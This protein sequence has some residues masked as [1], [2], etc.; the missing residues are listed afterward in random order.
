MHA[1]RAQEPDDFGAVAMI[2][3]A[4]R[5]PRRRPP[6]ANKRLA[7][8]IVT[9]QKRTENM[10]DVPVSISVVDAS[11]LQQ[12]GSKQL[13]DY[14]AYVPGMQVD[15]AGTPGQ[16][17]VSLRGIGPLGSNAT[18]GTY[19]DDAPIGSSGIYNSTN[20]LSFELLPYDIERIEV[21]RGPQGTL[22][23]ASSIGGLI[24]YVT[25]AP[26]LDE[27]EGRFG[28]EAVD[29]TDGSGNDFN[30]GARISFPLVKDSL[31][32]SLSYARR[33]L[34]AYVDNVQTGEAD[35]NEGTQEGARIAILWQPSATTSVSLSAM[36]QEVDSDDNALVYEDIN[37]VRGRRW[38]VDQP[39]SGRAVREPVR[40]VFS[41]AQLRDRRR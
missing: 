34:P 29:V 17:T 30:Y 15:S 13:T 38:P 14:S 36:R 9:A 12:G 35:V 32:M 37:G 19:I 1:N 33:E 24:K 8:I 22:Y 6:A 5:L 3:V 40:P 11:R 20:A 39:V 21:L 23:G 27:F 28:V 26:A 7:E 16:T 25:I 10:L 41:H 4:R 31:G 2:L 18:V